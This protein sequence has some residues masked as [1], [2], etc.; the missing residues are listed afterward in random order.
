MTAS[1][2]IPAGEAIATVILI[3]GLV[4]CWFGVAA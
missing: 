3:L 2:H 1:T 4:L